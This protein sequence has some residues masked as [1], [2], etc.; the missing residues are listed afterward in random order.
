[1]M[2][3]DEIAAS[4]VAKVMMAAQARITALQQT[5]VYNIS[6]EDLLKLDIAI[7]EANTEYWRARS[8]YE[9]I[10]KRSSAR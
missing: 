9:R 1:M 2:W 8:S 5:N 4:E 10:I 3:W 7:R 6:P